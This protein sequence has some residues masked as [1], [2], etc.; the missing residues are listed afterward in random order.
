MNYA[1][2]AALLLQ[3]P[4]QEPSEVF[5]RELKRFIGRAPSLMDRLELHGITPETHDVDAIMRHVMLGI[6]HR[7]DGSKYRESLVTGRLL[8]SQKAH[9]YRWPVYRP[10]AEKLLEHLSEDGLDSKSIALCLAA[11]SLPETPALR[12]LTDA[13]QAHLAP[14]STAG[15]F[16]AREYEVDVADAKRKQRFRR[17][18]ARSVAAKLDHCKYEGSLFNSRGQLCPIKIKRL[19]NEK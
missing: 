9:R 10:L 18:F 3:G 7:L 15:S 8:L 2:E 1:E 17:E 11:H 4:S 16:L 6:G 12:Q 5:R 13:I 14:Y 19:L